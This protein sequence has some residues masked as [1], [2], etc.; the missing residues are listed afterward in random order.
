MRLLPKTSLGID[1]SGSCINLAL[2]KTQDK[3]VK[4]LKTASAP[5]P[6][7]VIEDGNI[8]DPRTLAKAIAEL[9]TKNRICAHYVTLSL[10]AEPT[11]VQLLELP[12]NVPGNI[13]QFICDEVKH[14][15][16]LPINSVAV[17]YC[18]I[19]QFTESAQHRVLV[20]ATDNQKVVDVAKALSREGLTVDAVEPPWL[21]YLRTCYT[22]IIAN[23]PTSNLMFVMANEHVVTFCVFRNRGLDFVRTQRCE[24][25]TLG[26]EAFC[27]WLTEQIIAIMKFYELELP[28]SN[29]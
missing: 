4:V 12:E 11:L 13:R 22:T 20:V 21:A 29:R 1:V 3:G 9:R 23:K 19:K 10:V 5:V 2:L 16:V 14:F 26:T 18:G 24:P 7:G 17:D 27:D 28:D 8:K 15:A 25:G 6:E